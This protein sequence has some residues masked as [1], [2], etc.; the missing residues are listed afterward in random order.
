MIETSNEGWMQRQGVR[1][2][3]KFC[4]IGFTSMLIDI[5]VAWCLTY[6]LNWNWIL[7]RTIS[8]TF[9]VTNGYI[10]N[11]IWTFKGMGSG[12][13]HEQYMKFLAVNI[14]GLIANILIM[15]SV[16]F[17]FTGRIIHQGN[18]DKAHWIIAT[19]IAVVIVSCWNFVANK[20]WTFADAPVQA[21]S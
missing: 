16:F 20:K 15:K 14:V 19:G 6:K 8:F 18:P 21:T 1:Q 7:A 17:I 5:S 10:W 13:R 2:F 9:A 4:L 12:A 3:I 11:S